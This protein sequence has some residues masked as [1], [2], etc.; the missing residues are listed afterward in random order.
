MRWIREHTTDKTV[1]S[2][3]GLVKHGDTHKIGQEALNEHWLWSR[4]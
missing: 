3:V 4:N 2:Y 1:Q